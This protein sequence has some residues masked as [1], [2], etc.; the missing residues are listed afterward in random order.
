MLNIKIFRGIY[1]ELLTKVEQTRRQMVKSGMQHG[2][3]H[4]KTIQLSKRLDELLNLY[5]ESHNKR[6]IDIYKH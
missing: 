4:V 1:M 5:S 6:D 3:L 2:L